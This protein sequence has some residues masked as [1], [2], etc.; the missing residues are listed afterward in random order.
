MQK[1]KYNIKTIDFLNASLD[2]IYYRK[3]HYIS[4]VDLLNFKGQ[5]SAYFVQIERLF[6]YVYFSDISLDIEKIDIELLKKHFPFIYGN[7]SNKQFTMFREESEKV[8]DGITYYFYLI[9]Q[10][11]NMNLHAVISTKVARVFQVEESFM[12]VFPMLSDKLVYS[13]EGVLTIAGML[14][15]LMPILDEKRLKYLIGYLFQ[16]WGLELYQLEF[17]ESWEAQNRLIERLKNTFLTNYEVD[18]RKDKP[19]GDLLKDIFG[20]EYENLSIEEQ[21]KVYFQLDLSKRL[22]SPR[23]DVLGSLEKQEDSYL[24]TIEKGTNIGV[25][26]DNDFTIEIKDVEKFCEICCLV[27]PFLAVAYLYHNNVCFFDSKVSNSISYESFQKLN[28][29]KFYRDKNIPI[30]CYG[31]ENADI[32]EINKTASENLLRMFLDFEETIVFHYDIPIY[33]D[34]SKFSDITT[35][36]NVSQELKNK[37]ISCRNF[38]SHE[39]MLGN[40]HYSTKNSGYKITLPFICDTICELSQF[41]KNSG[42]GKEAFWIRNDLHKYVLNN[43]VAVKYKRVFEMSARLF[44]QSGDRVAETCANIQKSLGVVKN[45]CIDNV[46]E[47][48]LLRSMNEGFFF[49]IP[50]SLFETKED[51]FEFSKLRLVRICEEGLEIRGGQVGVKVLEFFQTPTTNLS[52]ISKNGKGIRLEKI[53]ETDNGLISVR[54]YKII[55]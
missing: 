6:R 4:G 40:F 14:A 43:I 39:G 7:F 29:A 31:N 36:L 48:A 50:Q 12:R 51:K 44:R 18:I 3:K 46:S 41:L 13:K 9:E 23:F 25:Y 2:E 22:N 54:T 5:M 8:V 1:K 37:L 26:F 34:W 21:D 15:L 47:T 55:E 32:R 38:C 33:G 11:R 42:K 20:R 16:N 19:C 53:E 45:S 27:P 24:L 30:L 17:K 10:L 35:A 49:Y 28:K 52:K